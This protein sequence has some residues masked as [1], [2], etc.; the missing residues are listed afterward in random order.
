MSAEPDGKLNEDKSC[1]VCGADVGD[2]WFGRIQQADGRILLC[3]P[4]CG[5]LYAEAPPPKSGQ[6]DR[7]QYYRDQEQLVRAAKAVSG[8]LFSYDSRMGKAAY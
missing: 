7:I 4:R 5:M 6:P 1:F 2:R 8:E 3:S